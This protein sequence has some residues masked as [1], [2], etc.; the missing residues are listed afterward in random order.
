LDADTGK[1]LAKGEVVLVTYDYREEKTVSIPQEW[2]EKII[3]F[4]KL[5]G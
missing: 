4:E 2:R 5:G 1:E 3:A